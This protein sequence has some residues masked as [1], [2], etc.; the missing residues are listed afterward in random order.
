MLLGMAY[1]A[2]VGGMGTLIGT[3]PNAIFAGY[4]R[5]TYGFNISFLDWMLFAIP[6]VCVLI[7]VIYLILT[8][9]MYPNRMGHI[10]KFGEIVRDELEEMGDISK[11]EKMT[12]GLFCTAAFMW[13][14]R[15]GIN[16]L[17]GTSIGDTSI[18][19]FIGVLFFIIP[20]SSKTGERLLEWKDTTKLP[21]GVLILFGGG[22]SIASALSGTGILTIFANNISSIEGMSL[23]LITI[24]LMLVVVILTELM[25]NTAL[26]T[27]FLPILCSLGVSFGM[28]PVVFAAPMILAMSCVF[29]LPMGTPPNAVIFASGELKISNMVRVGIM[30]D[31]IAVLIL[32]FA[33]YFLS[34][35]FLG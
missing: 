16:Q 33:G 3:P 34:H 25:S 32:S 11:E 21:W 1:G 35:F 10:D 12:L 27:I 4:I 19:I 8:K 7:F 17:L 18:A 24:I 9:V 31:P 29:S 15:G 22:L 13:I 20:T 23:V 6:L 5:S 30:L 14:T 26:A 2:N 28:E